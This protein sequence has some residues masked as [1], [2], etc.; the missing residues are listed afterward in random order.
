VVS[1]K[2]GAQI[3]IPG[4]TADRGTSGERAAGGA[5]RPLELSWK[6]SNCHVFAAMSWIR[7]LWFDARLRTDS[8][9]P[10]FAYKY[11]GISRAQGEGVL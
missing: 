9:V 5:W 4:S 11:P 1:S 3:Q 8:L 10:C 7:A 2:P 6:C